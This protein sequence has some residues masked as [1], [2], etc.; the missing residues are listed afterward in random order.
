MT[1]EQK[2]QLLI[3]RQTM[4]IMAMEAE[5]ERLKGELEKLKPSGEPPA[6]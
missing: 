1:A 2:L 3:G 4:L 5:I 6:A